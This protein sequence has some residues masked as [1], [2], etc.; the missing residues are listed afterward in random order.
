MDSFDQI[1]AD[2]CRML[3]PFDVNLPVIVNFKSSHQL[4]RKYGG[5]MTV[6]N[7]VKKQDELFKNVHLIKKIT[8]SPKHGKSIRNVT[9]VHNILCNVKH[10]TAYILD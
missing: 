5:N 7:S 6:V 10:D 4:C 1:Q 2:F 9:N 8:E 3:K